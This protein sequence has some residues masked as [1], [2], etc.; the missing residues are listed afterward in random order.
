[1]FTSGP[2]T[3]RKTPESTNRTKNVHQ[4][5][6]RVTW[7]I[8][9]SATEDPASC[10]KEIAMEFLQE[11]VQIDEKITILQWQKKGTATPINEAGTMPKTVTGTHKF[12]H[13]L[14]MPKAGRDTIIYP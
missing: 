12:F 2:R 11:L 1:M 10:V 14:F 8:S 7:K 5:K 4:Y 3:R 9:V 13:R 6:T